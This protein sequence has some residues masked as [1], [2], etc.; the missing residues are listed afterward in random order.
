MT[1]GV[2][3]QGQPAQIIV[4]SYRATKWWRCRDLNPG[5]LRDKRRLKD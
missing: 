3:E 2:V 5:A 1:Y 4:I